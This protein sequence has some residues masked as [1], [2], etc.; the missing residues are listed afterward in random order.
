MV[1][2][3][4]LEKKGEKPSK[5]TIEQGSVQR[6]SAQQDQAEP[7]HLSEFH[8]PQP[9]HDAEQDWRAR[10]L[11][12]I[13]N[14]QAIERLE[15]NN[16]SAPQQDP[17][18]QWRAL[19]FT[20]L[21]EQQA[22]DKKEKE[23]LSGLKPPSEHPLLDLS[24]NPLLPHPERSPTQPKEPANALEITPVLQR[25]NNQAPGGSPA[26][27]TGAN[28]RAR[29]NRD[30]G[31]DDAGTPQ[32]PGRDITPQ[33]QVGDRFERDWRR[34]EA[35]QIQPAPNYDDRERKQLSEPGKLP[36]SDATAHPS[37]ESRLPTKLEGVIAV[38]SVY[39][40]ARLAAAQTEIAGAIRSRSDLELKLEYR[41]T[42]SP[43]FAVGQGAVDGLRDAASDF[44]R[45][46]FALAPQAVLSRQ[47]QSGSEAAF[48][49][50]GLKSLFASQRAE[51]FNLAPT[52]F[53]SGEMS[54]LPKPD[55]AITSSLSAM[56][57]R[58]IEGA[59]SIFSSTRSSEIFLNPLVAGRSIF[60]DNSLSPASAVKPLEHVLAPLTSAT[61]K[62]LEPFAATLYVP[63]GRTIETN[64][65]AF[66]PT[67]NIRQVVIDSRIPAD[68]STVIGANTSTRI[69][70][71]F[72][73][74]TVGDKSDLP[75]K[76]T[77]QPTSK[78]Q[79]VDQVGN[80]TPVLI[81][82]QFDPLGIKYIIMSGRTEFSTANSNN[83]I[84]WGAI[85]NTSRI[86]D[87]RV[88]AG[89][90]GQMSGLA[91]NSGPE[92]NPRF[93]PDTE[94]YVGKNHSWLNLIISE[95]QS[96]PGASI[97]LEP[98][99]QE[100][101]G[102][103]E[104]PNSSEKGE[105]G[106][107][108]ILDLENA[109]ERQSNKLPN[110]NPVRRMYQIGKEDTLEKLAE[111]LFNDGS[112]AFLI[113]E[114]NQSRLKETT[115]NGGRVIELM[116][117][118]SIELPNSDDVDKFLKERARKIKPTANIVSFVLNSLDSSDIS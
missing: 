82:K 7:E 65:A 23:N 80:R 21:Q 113:A 102:A 32:R 36:L 53:S 86:V 12:Q 61:T 28:R 29:N 52:K 30:S 34:T 9:K 106:E 94:P 95:K 11:A 105:A 15:K 77:I 4:A 118:Q 37:S 107:I 59:A 100:Q 31:D 39:P 17:E 51:N 101:V 111:R 115:V 25:Q 33:D 1:D 24:Q 63:G 26:D 2:G 73:P 45:F 84:R 44:A 64:L 109:V 50:Q 79:I 35:A 85:T 54:S 46:K 22:I 49:I 116:L 91:T 93:L 42:G 83:T 72:A 19:E 81:E 8:P 68:A 103:E 13:Q 47:E 75:T 71:G 3:E 112:L 40:E 92:R 99:I 62:T 117:G 20:K 114:L 58:N 16:L 108:E 6:R 110:L 96:Q 5:Q 56:P 88:L 10:E 14:Q 69:P 43:S 38:P 67:T 70:I 18:K 104:T 66:Q 48:A 90:D 98:L 41:L 74:G 87:A 78:T 60:V 27:E 89:T 57:N 55:S 76:F 97:L